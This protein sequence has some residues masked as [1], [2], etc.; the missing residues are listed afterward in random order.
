MFLPPPIFIILWFLR[1][2][3]AICKISNIAIDN[4]ERLRSAS[5][6][7][8]TMDNSTTAQVSQLQFYSDPL[9][10]KFL[11]SVLA[12]CLLVGFPANLLACR[13]LFIAVNLVSIHSSTY[14]STYTSTYIHLGLYSIHIPVHLP[15]HL[16]I[17]I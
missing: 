15:I 13:Y 9:L 3:L 10:D 14:T 16:P 17:Y 2:K 11:A 5:P 7:I 1:V 6:S 12:L 4:I 8:Y